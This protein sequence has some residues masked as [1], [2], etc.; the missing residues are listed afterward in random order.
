MYIC[1][2]EL[3]EKLMDPGRESATALFKLMT[4]NR[5]PPAPSSEAD[6][7]SRLFRLAYDGGAESAEALLDYVQ[8]L[9]S[10]RPELYRRLSQRGGDFLWFVIDTRASHYFDNFFTDT[11]KIINVQQ[12]LWGLLG[13][14]FRFMWEQ[15][16]YVCSDIPVQQETEPITDDFR[17]E[18]VR[19]VKSRT[20]TT[21]LSPVTLSCLLEAADASF[22]EHFGPEFAGIGSRSQQYSESF[23]GYAR[24]VVNGFTERMRESKLNQPDQWQER[25]EGVAEAALKKLHYVL[26]KQ[27]GFRAPGSPIID[28]STPLFSP[29]S[30]ATMLDDWLSVKDMVYMVSEYQLHATRRTHT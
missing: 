5:L 1:L 7:L 11:T 25:D 9:T 4:N 22:D 18:F 26:L 24:D 6:E 14:F 29:I 19:L 30:A 15:L 13:P 21:Y 16:L 28:T 10:T 17:Q 23:Q 12:E 3:I 2:T 27:V 20:R 8:S